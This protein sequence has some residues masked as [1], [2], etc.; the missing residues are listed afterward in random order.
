MFAQ[1]QEA[2]AT[3]E[4]R[5][6]EKEKRREVRRVRKQRRLQRELQKEVIRS[7]QQQVEQIE[8]IRRTK[9]GSKGKNSKAQAGQQQGQQSKERRG[10]IAI[11]KNTKVEA[12]DTDATKKNKDSNDGTAQDT[13]PSPS[14]SDSL[15]LGTRPNKPRR[16][17][18]NKYLLGRSKSPHASP[19]KDRGA[20]SSMLR[21]PST[22]PATPTAGLSASRRTRPIK[23][24]SRF[25]MRRPVSTEKLDQLAQHSAR[26][27]TKPSASLGLPLSPSMPL[28]SQ[29][30]SFPEEQLH[31]QQHHN[32][33][34]IVDT[35]NSKANLGNSVVIDIPPDDQLELS[36]K[37]NDDD[38]FAATSD[39][40]IVI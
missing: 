5:N 16:S 13:K 35:N 29:A 12:L 2:L 36:D 25:G 33:D 30:A 14:G 28:I 20:A 34:A 8:H 26:G 10:K 39:L 11:K 38:S 17:S 27:E 4:K 1:W 3:E 9:S 7:K 18:S 32:N 22:A 19:R 31:G 23:L 6:L 40:G 37:D 15:L 24:L 21:E